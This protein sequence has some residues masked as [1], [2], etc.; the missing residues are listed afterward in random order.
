ML[1][2]KLAG[3]VACMQ[4]ETVKLKHYFASLSR[5]TEYFLFLDRIKPLPSGVQRFAKD[6]KFK[7]DFEL[8]LT[9]FTCNTLSRVMNILINRAQNGSCL[10]LYEIQPQLV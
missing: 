5:P 7:S 9:L 2:E 6:T 4:S 8:N 1:G 3:Q 10:L